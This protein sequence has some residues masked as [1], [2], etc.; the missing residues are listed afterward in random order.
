[1]TSD[2]VSRGAKAKLGRRLFYGAIIIACITG[3]VTLIGM[4][5]SNTQ[6]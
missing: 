2:T 5:L 1:M 6:R 3:D 4:I